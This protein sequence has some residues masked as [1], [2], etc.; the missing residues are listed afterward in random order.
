MAKQ[1]ENRVVEME[2][3]NKDFEKAVS[4]TMK[5]LEEL[6]EKLD[7]LNNVNVS[8]FENITDK[9]NN[10]N[11]DK[12]SENIDYLKGRFSFL[13]E[14]V[15]D[16]WGDIVDGA[17]AAM[18]KIEQ[19]ITKPLDI[20]EEKGKVRATNIAQA[21]FQ[22]SNL[23]VSW[24]AIKEDIDYAVNDTRFG[25]DEA[26]MAASQLSASGVKIGDEMKKALLGI[27]GVAAM[28]NSEYSD[29]AHIFT[30]I[31]GTGKV[32]TQQLNMIASRGLNATAALAKKLETT[33]A[34]VREILADKDEF[35]DFATFA[36]AMYDEYGPS[37]KKGNDLFSG[38]LANVKAALGRI[39]EK[40]YTP[41]Y[42]DARQILVAIKPVINDINSALTP[43]FNMIA[44]GMEHI[45]DTAVYVFDLVHSALDPNN[46][47]PVILHIF[48]DP[49][50]IKSKLTNLID[51]INTAIDGIVDTLTGSGL[52]SIV[53]ETLVNVF[54]NIYEVVNLI[55]GAF[56]DVFGEMDDSGIVF[57]ADQFRQFTE[58]LKLNGDE[59][60]SLRSTLGGL[61]AIFDIL[62][63]TIDSIFKIFIKPLIPGLR[64]V[65]DGILG[66]TGDVGEMLK[67]FDEVY[68]PFIP[69][70]NFAAE[71]STIFA[72]P[73]RAIK[74]LVH[75]IIE[76]FQKLTGITS[77]EEFFTKLWDTISS[78]HLENIIL[79]IVG[80]IALGIEKLGILLEMLESSSSLKDYLKNLADQSAVLTWIKDKFT[81]IKN[82]ISDLLNKRITLS[83][84][85]GLDKLAEKF[86][87]LTPII[88]KFK[89]HYGSIFEAFKNDKGNEGLPFLTEVEERLKE[90]I[91]NLKWEDIFG[92]IGA[93]F[94]GY[95]AKKRAEIA[96]RLADYVGSF[97]ETFQQLAEGINMSLNKMTKETKAEQI[98][99]IAAGVALLAGSVFLLAQLEP[100][101]VA[102]A[103][104]AIVGIMVVLVAFVALLDKVM[105]TSRKTNKD[106][107]SIMDPGAK[108]TTK[109]KGKG[110]N[111]VTTIVE[112]LE[113]T[114]TETKETIEE[115][116]KNFGELPMLILSFA[117]V[118]GMIALA[119]GHLAHIASADRDAFMDAVT[120]TFVIMGAVMGI[121]AMLMALSNSSM[122][123]NPA[124]LKAVSKFFIAIAVMI[125][126]MVIP[127][128]A[129][130]GLLAATHGGEVFVATGIIVGLIALLAGIALALSRF[131]NVANAGSIIAGGAAM[132]L[133]AVAIGLLTIPLVAL[134][135]IAKLG[136]LDEAFWTV[137]NLVIELGALAIL[138]GILNRGLGGVQGMLA[139]SAAMVIMAIALNA[140]IAPLAAVEALAAASGDSQAFEKATQTLEDL[141]GIMAFLVIVFGIVSGVVTA[142]TGGAGGAIVAA[143]MVAAAAAIW[144]IAKAVQGVCLALAGMVALE[145][146]FPNGV[147]KFLTD[148][149]VGLKNLASIKVVFI[150]SLLAAVLPPIAT[151]FL[152]FGGGVLLITK[153]I[154]ALAKALFYLASA[155]LVLQA[156]DF[157]KVGQNIQNGGAAFIHGFV[158]AMQA[159]I[160]DIEQG[161]YL[162]IGAGLNALVGSG[163]MISETLVKLLADVI[164]SIDN[165]SQVLGFYLGHALTNILLFAVAGVAAAG[166]DFFGMM[167]GLEEGEGMT[168]LLKK[169]LLEGKD[170]DQISEAEAKQMTMDLGKK[171]GGSL[172]ENTLEGIAS[173]WDVTKSTFT[174]NLRMSIESI[175][176]SIDIASIL[177]GIVAGPKGVASYAAGT[178]FGSLIGRI[179]RKDKNTEQEVKDAVQPVAEDAGKTTTDAIKDSL[180]SPENTQKVTE[181]T[182][183]LLANGIGNIDPAQFY[184]DLQN[185]GEG[186]GDSLF[187]GIEKSM[188]FNGSEATR[189]NDLINFIDEPMIN[190]DKYNLQD[191]YN[192]GFNKVDAQFKGMQEAAD[193]ASPSKRAIKLG[194][195]I[196]EGLAIG[197]NS[198][199]MGS[200]AAENEVDDLFSVF[201]SLKT[202]MADSV[203]G[204][205]I[206]SLRETIMSMAEA[207]TSDAM[208][209][210]P[211][212]SPVL[213]MS[214]IQSGF[215]S[216][217]SMFNRERSFALAGD[218]SSMDAANR[219]M[220]LEIQ[221]DK[222]S[223]FMTGFNSLGGK[224]DKLG[225]A[226][227]NR[228]IVLDSGELVGGLRDPMDRSLGVKTIRAQRSGRR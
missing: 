68:N 214:N 183:N 22:L 202:S 204:S 130:T 45:K 149:A 102:K 178:G 154:E 138:M 98:L 189:A 185:V 57:V 53:G 48:G 119:I 198:S 172:L 85:L 124:A 132:V 121:A 101:D 213:D 91:K 115:K 27:S 83:Q 12:L 24:N 104:A 215:A 133:M 4:V 129:I 99:K 174:N 15:H 136:T 147:E 44:T 146:K 13:G 14:A 76:E 47:E 60:Q 142:A 148:L 163:A 9:L 207:A 33:E 59:I 139:G 109:T 151:A 31:A 73:I 199:D 26:A 217:D 177:G 166:I 111:A 17:E 125:N 190:G 61:L 135:A 35:I 112:T 193:S 38:A 81:A 170:A 108:K 157:E 8:G 75:S 19:T 87:W 179:F 188:G 200:Q 6:N 34:G 110:K 152:E 32:Y 158:T 209:F 10:T 1:V 18:A 123:V 72:R 5:S 211:T 205:A 69:I 29:I 118:V 79:G 223:S 194:G 182:Q 66:V 30:T 40:F 11:F 161:I 134:S 2:F 42:E 203:D 164:I 169:R 167:L 120:V 173:K 221:N 50:D 39:G 92:M 181:G 137:T 23:G 49:V 86:T 90:A 7:S 117:A 126:M 159:G 51:W 156:I 222:S 186:G 160:P 141:I 155:L 97:T 165:Y 106:I 175:F 180:E 28:T 122:N 107:T 103:T 89:E 78:L 140:M 77:V 84:A 220:S 127:L 67:A 171:L 36:E 208:D 196:D 52:T 74:R 95:L 144:I 145:Y 58:S 206:K 20:I 41:F 225:E 210:T 105:E 128:A 150:L 70:R 43:M 143:S 80:A 168:A 113:A 82:T 21:K 192:S 63:K 216:L 55:V 116:I 218:V 100:A 184:E 227:M 16:I 25:L 224:L 219:M 131:V 71:M 46:D 162:W 212:I 201:A 191:Y 226:I 64:D 153:S 94:Y 56:K 96:G 54:Y 62:F 65:D 176:K 195:Y 228:Q 3:K 88:D 187:A 197:L 114:L 37:A 93:G